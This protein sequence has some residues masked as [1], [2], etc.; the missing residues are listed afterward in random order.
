MATKKTPARR[1]S[2]PSKPAPKAAAAKPA[3]PSIRTQGGL[4][5]RPRAV[6]APAP[7]AAPPQP[8]AIA[9]PAAEPPAV[10]GR[11]PMPSKG[12]NDQEHLPPAGS[13]R[14][15]YVAELKRQAERIRE[16]E[17]QLQAKAEREQARKAPTLAEALAIAAP[18]G[19]W[20]ADY[21]GIRTSIYSFRYNKEGGKD[22]LP[23]KR[24]NG[25]ILTMPRDNDPGK[26]GDGAFARAS[27]MIACHLGLGEDGESLVQAPAYLTEDELPE[28]LVRDEDGDVELWETYSAAD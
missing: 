28:L 1:T 8:R 3:A 5:T 11:K 6:D 25:V 10:R 22:V 2:A 15:D 26:R 4:G 7:K 9:I 21:V 20:R 24:F 18:K 17:A 23:E 12:T 16:L 27:G 14:T 19:D 13:P